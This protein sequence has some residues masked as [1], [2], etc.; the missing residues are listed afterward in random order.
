MGAREE[1]REEGSKGQSEGRREGKRDGGREGSPIV[2]QIIQLHAPYLIS[3]FS[4]GEDPSVNDVQC[5]HGN[6]SHG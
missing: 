3:I 5:R 1:R 4:S 6:C 2:C